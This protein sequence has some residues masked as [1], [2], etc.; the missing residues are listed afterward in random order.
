MW[1][2]EELLR[3]H[4]HQVGAGTNGNGPASVPPPSPEQK[5]IHTIQRTYELAT[6]ALVIAG[7]AFSLALYV[8]LA[9]APK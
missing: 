8:Y 5:A 2:R 7:M 1:T 3:A 9:R 4:A 6:A